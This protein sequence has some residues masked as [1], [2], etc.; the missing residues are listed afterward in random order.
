MTVHVGS[1]ENRRKKFKV[2][3]V[4]FTSYSTYFKI[5]T[6]SY[7]TSFLLEPTWNEWC[8]SPELY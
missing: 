5:A 2:Y 3:A 8:D 7:I 1:L 4:H 6:A